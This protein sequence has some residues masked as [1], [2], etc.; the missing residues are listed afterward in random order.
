MKITNT[1]CYGCK[2]NHNWQCVKD[3]ICTGR[4]TFPSYVSGTIAP[5]YTPANTPIM[6]DEIEINGVKYRK[7][8]E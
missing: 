2:Y 7:V 8:K 4:E 5:N 3:G 6:P 1:D